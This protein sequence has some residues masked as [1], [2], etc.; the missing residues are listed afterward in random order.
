S[1]QIT[2]AT[3][4][5]I[6]EG[7][8]QRGQVLQILGNYLSPESR[9]RRRAVHSFY[10][11]FHQMEESEKYQLV[12]DALGEN[13]DISA[14][15]QLTRLS[16]HDLYKILFYFLKQNMLIVDS[17]QEHQQL[18]NIEDGLATLDVNLK[19]IEQRPVMF[20][21]YKTSAELCA[22]LMRASEDELLRFAL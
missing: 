4:D 22:D 9:F 19:R 17:E 20:T 13:I 12:W 18:F 15:Q 3:S 2:R 14:L 16:K 5:L 6:Y 1:R 8:V 7:L 10:T 11:N 21:Y